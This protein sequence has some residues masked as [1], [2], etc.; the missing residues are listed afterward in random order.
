METFAVPGP[1]FFPDDSITDLP[2]KVI[3]AEII[4]EKL[5]TNLYDEIPH[6][7]AVVIE[8][9]KERPDK[10]LID[11]DAEIFCEKKSHKGMIIGKG[12]V[13]LKKIATEARLEI[14]DFLGV[15]VNLQCW[16][17]VKDDWRDNDF[18]LNN[19]GFEK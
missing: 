18:L 19:F 15:R 9:F 5:L 6:G 4:R 16:V 7:T 3:A 8:K 13:M 14:E 10:N 12:G 17:K 11:I 1:H 2:E